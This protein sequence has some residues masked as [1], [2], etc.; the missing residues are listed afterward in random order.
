M[1]ELSIWSAML[2]ARVLLPA[3]PAP[4]IATRTVPDLLRRTFLSA[5]AWE[6]RRLVD[7]LF[8]L[9]IRKM[10]PQQDSNL[11]TRLRRPLLYPLS[12]GGWRNTRTSPRQ[13]RRERGATGPQSA[14]QDGDRPAEEP[15]CALQ[16]SRAARSR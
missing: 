8:R 2:A 6:L 1:Y 4:S 11:R 15:I 9:H 10:R 5:H 12:Y 3:P 14:Y 16:P 7:L 13:A